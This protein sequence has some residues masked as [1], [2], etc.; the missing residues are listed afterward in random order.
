MRALCA[1]SACYSMVLAGC[2]T[3]PAENP[4]YAATNAE[5][6]EDYQRMGKQPVALPR[7]V[8][9]LNGYHAPPLFA[10]NARDWIV[11][12]TG[13]PD[14]Q[15]MAISYPFRYDIPSIA[16]EVVREVD[17]RW[18][19]ASADGTVD[20]DV[21]A[22]S[23]GGLVA[24]EAAMTPDAAAGTPARKRLKIK[25]LFTLATPHRGANLADWLRPDEASRQMQRGSAYLAR[26]D[27]GLAGADYELVCYARLHD[28]IVGATNAAPVGS[29]PIWVPGLVV[30]SHFGIANDRRILVDVA[31]R[32]RGEEPLAK[33]G[34]APPRD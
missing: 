30:G 8:V 20:V 1:I 15:V 22:I 13:A 31:R 24:R 16:E 2:M 17:E 18:P 9:I 21:V 33:S 19:S 34:A 14:D 7:P 4:D 29:E 5:V 12:L 3:V 25:R 27:A 11:E 23:M 26:L 28:E 32:L 10:W 6:D